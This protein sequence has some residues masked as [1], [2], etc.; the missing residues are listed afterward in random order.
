MTLCTSCG[1]G[2]CSSEAVEFANASYHNFTGA[3]THGSH[4]HGHGNSYHTSTPSNSYHNSN[5]S[6]SSNSSSSRPTTHGPKTHIWNCC[7]CGGQ[8]SYELNPG[9]TNY[10]QRGYCGHWVEGCAYCKIEEVTPRKG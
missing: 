3:S 4:T 9:C 2:M 1:V 10:G 6:N 8:N 7:Q 5:A